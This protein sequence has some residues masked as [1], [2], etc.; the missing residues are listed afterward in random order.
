MDAKDLVTIVIGYYEIIGTGESG[1]FATYKDK[2]PD[3]LRMASGR[4][5]LKFSGFQNEVFVAKNLDD[6]ASK[7][8]NEL[9]FQDIWHNNNYAFEPAE[10][11]THS[12]ATGHYNESLMYLTRPIGYEDLKKLCTILK[13][14]IKP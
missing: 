3:V 4:D 11:K 7:V 5:S 2:A 9:G 1:Y 6:L 12:V 10:M 8:R 13:R 14:E